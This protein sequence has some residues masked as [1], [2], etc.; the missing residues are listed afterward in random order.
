MR[1]DDTGNFAI[2]DS[3]LQ[4]KPLSTTNLQ[5]IHFALALVVLWPTQ[6]LLLKKATGCGLAGDAFLAPNTDEEQ[7]EANGYC[8]A[9]RLFFLAE[10]AGLDFDNKPL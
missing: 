1:C 9:S 5:L 4:R 8:E 3:K 6:Q 10:A 7:N 2:F